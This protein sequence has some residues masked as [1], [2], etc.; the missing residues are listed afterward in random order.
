MI[1]SNTGG[2]IGALYSVNG[3]LTIS[4][5]TVTNNTA[6]QVGAI[7]NFGTPGTLAI[8]NSTVTGNGSQNS[9]TG[10]IRNSSSTPA[11]IRNTIV[12]GNTGNNGA[13]AS[14]VT[15]P[16]ASGGYNLIG[17]TAGSSGF[18]ATGD[19]IGATFAQA[20]LGPLLD[21]GGATYTMRPRPGSLAI[22]Q[23]KR[24]V[25]ASGQPIN[26]DQRGYPRPIDLA[27]PNAF[28][29]DGSDIGAVETGP[30]QSGNFTVTNTADHNDGCTTDDCT[31]L[32][33]IAAAN[34]N[35]DT[36]TITFAAGVGPVI[37]NASQTSGIPITA[38]V[39]IIGPGARQLAISGAGF[40]RIF[41]VTSANVAISGLSLTS[42]RTI[43]A[44]GAAINN[45]GGLS[46]TN[47]SVRSSVVADFGGGGGSGGG[48]FNASGATATLTGCTFTGNAASQFGG[49]VFSD[50]MITITN[51]TF[52]N[53]SAV[54]GGGVIARANGGASF[55]TMRNCTIAGNT[56]TD[57][58][59]MPGFGG[60]GLY[61]EGGLQQHFVGNS[62]IAANSSTNDPDVRGQ[63][64]SDGNNLIGSAGDSTGFSNGSNGDKVGVSAFLDS[65]GDHGGQTDTWS[66]LG[67]SPAI[68]MGNNSIA[69][70][71]DQ[72]GYARNGVSDMGAFEFNGTA[73]PL[74]PLTS[75][76]S[77]KVHGAQTF[78]I[79]L[80]LTGSPGVECRT[81][82]AN[83][84]FT[85]IFTFA[86]T[87]TNVGG[88][89]LTSGAGL[90][91]QALE[92]I[93][94]TRTNT[95]SS[96][97]VLLTHRLSRCS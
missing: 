73:P 54:R 22:D 33:A 3:S 69:P 12:V 9:S 85:V 72:R 71:K 18:G 2:A 15:G 16:Y 86:N 63:Y 42:G 38:P 44:N 77:S 84:D 35:G 75:V 68:N 27:P 79:N 87:L 93:R 1:Y 24:G 20:N 61:C 60:G 46:L 64:T 23:G 51:C 30:A 8:D 81:G 88:V 49:G 31:L 40:L 36:N 56:A 6:F 83:G 29:G 43:D 70:Q 13:V 41:N 37:V 67:S 48:L 28:G 59:A 66:L 39:S 7:E 91:Q 89:S 57:G 55:I 96:S 95:L 19:Q 34:A 94:A 47:C 74:V 90:S 32:E 45:S 52:Y 58:V 5:C 25:D 50:G 80:P 92:S 53:N 82:G 97:R 17:T 11:Q 21:Y 62:I 4:R 76:V 14:D 26:T 10:G 78:G 65:F